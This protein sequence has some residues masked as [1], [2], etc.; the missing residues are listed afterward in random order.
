MFYRA[1]GLFPY[2]GINRVIYVFELCVALHVRV[3]ANLHNRRSLLSVNRSPFG[4][5]ESV[6]IA[7][8]HEVEIEALEYVDTVKSSGCQSYTR[9]VGRV[10]IAYSMSAE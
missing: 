2:H 4:Q 9:L 8:L 6:R 1:G 5:A 7:C 3:D 10:P